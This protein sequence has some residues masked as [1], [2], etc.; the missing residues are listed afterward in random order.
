MSRLQ[1]YPDY[2]LP[3]TSIVAWYTR[4]TFIVIFLVLLGALV[5]VP[6]AEY[7]SAVLMAAVNFSLICYACIQLLK[8]LRLSSLVPFLF[9]VWVAVGWPLST[10]VFGLIEP[11]M[12]YDLPVGRRY[13]LDGNLRI[14]LSVLL[15]LIAYLTTFFALGPRN[16]RD[17]PIQVESERAR[18]FLKVVLPICLGETLLLAMIYV[19]HMENALSYFVQ[20]FLKYITGLYLIVGA[21]ILAM[22]FSTKLIISLIL[23]GTGFVFLLGNSR[24]L[25]ANPVVLIFAGV[26]FLS[27]LK[28]K[29]KLSILLMGTIGMPILLVIGNT[30]RTLLGNVGK[31]DIS[32]RLHAMGEWNEVLRESSVILSTFGRLFS[33]GGHAIITDSPERVPFMDFSLGRYCLDVFSSLFIPER[34]WYFAPY[35]NTSI[36]N[37]YGFRIILGGHS[38]ELSMIGS[39]WMLGGFLAVFL[40]GMLVGILH[41]MI[42]HWINAASRRSVLKGLFYLSGVS[43]QILWGQNL[44]F[45]AHLKVVVWSAFFAVLFY[46]IIIKPLSGCEAAQSPLEYGA[47]RIR[48]QLPRTA[49][50]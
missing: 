18:S 9:L 2:H 32:A 4:P 42:A 5:L 16:R 19:T 23:C 10:V 38:V 22:R 17:L 40:G 36:L 1:Q 35:S 12:Y 33:T 21:L 29:T 34:I 46:H 3:P 49:A 25:A 37:S 50:W 41:T 13:M 26:L 14:Q 28:Q 31:A 6:A 48:T 47:N 44:A 24:G 30:T 7:R 15:F 8:Q 20:G 45:P 11:N 27:T 43:F 39:F